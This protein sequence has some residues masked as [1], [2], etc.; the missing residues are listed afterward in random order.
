MARS[1]RASRYGYLD[2]LRILA[3]FFVIVN[4]TNSYVFK[5]LTPA[6]PTWY[7]SIAWYYLSK[8]AVPLFVMVSGACLLPK[9]DSYRRIGL[10][11]LR[12]VVALVLF[13]YLYYL[14]EVWKAGGSAAAALTFGGFFRALWEK[15][16]TDSFWYLYFDIGLLI[17]VPL[18][19]RLAKGMQ[20]RDYGYFLGIAFG[21]N[22]L[23]PL[24]THYVPSL[25]LPK[26]LDLPLFSVF[27]GLF[28][29]GHYLHAYVAP[30]GWHLWVGGLLILALPLLSTALTYGEYH[31]VAPG[32]KYWFMDER[33]APALPVVLCALAVMLLT[34]AAFA[35]RKKGEPTPK[36]AR[37]LAALGGCAFPIYLLQD[38]L[39]VETRHL[40]FEPL[41]HMINPFLAGLVW[42]AGI[43]LV[44]LPIAWLLKKLP[45]VRTL[46]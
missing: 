36:T 32:Q 14:F 20:K 6:N 26:Y 38:L 40:V 15:P 3:C 19:Q 31:R 34:R 33:T 44:L 18:L 45:G 28:F 39:T 13:S 4:H 5:A 43:F 22:G 37:A 30:K 7:L 2:L 35:L 29:A 11:I 41:A 10:R 21:V 24:L 42:S 16:L 17:M 46:I 27:L 23:W 1:A 8:I 9:E 25:A 12:M